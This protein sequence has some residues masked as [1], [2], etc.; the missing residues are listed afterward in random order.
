MR[1]TETKATGWILAA[2]VA[3]LLAAPALAAKQPVKHPPLPRARPAAIAAAKPARTAPLPRPRPHKAATARPS[4]VVPAPRPHDAKAAAVS[5]SAVVPM[6]APR[7]QAAGQ[8]VAASIADDH[9]VSAYA[10]T[11]FNLSALPP[12][13]SSHFEPLAHPPA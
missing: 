12:P 3:G 6:P 1:R 10:E 8:A 11:N 5:P 9:L 2:I 4:A 7:P 13:A